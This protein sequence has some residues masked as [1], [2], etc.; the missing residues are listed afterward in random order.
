[1]NTLAKRIY[2]FGPYRLDTAERV[3]LRG[4]Q[5]VALAPK[6]FDVLLVLVE[7]SGHIV[8]KDQLMNRVWADSFVEEG[9]LKV[10]VSVL[11]KALEDGPFIETVP[12]RGYRFVATVKEVSSESASLVVR[13]R[14][15][16]SVTIEESEEGEEHELAKAPA[17]KISSKTRVQV[18]IA[19][20]VV[21]GLAVAGFL[22]WIN[23]P[24]P[25]PE[26]KSIAVLPFKPLLAE[27][28]DE[29]LE[30]GM[31][32]ATITKLS[33]IKQ[34]IVRSTGSILK[35]RDVEQDPLAIG[36]EQNV[37]LLLEGKVQRSGDNLRVTVQ[38]VRVSDGLPLWADKFDE[39]FTNIF[40]VQDSISRR[41][42][43]ALAL[44][45][46]GEQKQQITKRYTDNI[47]AYNLYLQGRFFWNKF[48]EDGL[49]KAI[50]YFKQ[51]IALDP[52]YALAYT[53]LSVAYNVQGAYGIVPPAETW[54]EARRTAQKAVDLADSLPEAHTALGGI[55][56]LYEW[57]WPIAEKEL[58]RAIELN[59][60]YAD[61]HELYGFYFWVVG[62]LDD[63]FSEI[64]RARELAPVSPVINL[65][66]STMFYYQTNYEEAIKAYR[67][68]Q[69]IDPNILAPTFLLGQIYERNGE[70]GRAV[71]ECQ[72]ALSAFGRDPGVLSA[73]GYVY[74]VN[75]SR[76]Q[77]QEI[78][79][80][81]EAMWKARYFS[82][83]VIAL[84]YAGV[85]NK[86]QAFVWLTKA[87]ESRDPQLIWL[88]VEPQFQT[89]RPDPR[90]QALL[91]RMGI[92]Q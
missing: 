1:M 44:E 52:D 23:R 24:A 56:L 72:G 73:L 54:T 49:K 10:T 17:A 25:A 68:T 87:Y 58:K 14:T 3:L 55:K 88:K 69:E 33:N 28:R 75:G 36:R 82:P 20:V 9:N 43:E 85:G 81:L 22:L 13:E 37:D 89:L 70:Y 92:P 35:Y 21:V 65:D 48:S 83:S 86:D 46:S 8:E 50:E 2:E 4:G 19:L 16:S 42:A 84:A 63:A 29:A 51:A 62:E 59:P 67:K 66:L 11:R 34:L 53:G 7:S 74:G 47:E 41:V 45:L 78:I 91:R 60:N 5:P 61:A 77:A 6:A 32:D 80:E 90:F 71:E 27:N 79:N 15:T 40:S 38:L 57:D 39:K 31:A 18:A 30:L 26:L 76:R 64:K 12:R